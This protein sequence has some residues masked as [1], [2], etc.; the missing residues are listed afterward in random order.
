M[1][2]RAR[3]WQENDATFFKIVILSV[4]FAREGSL[5]SRQAVPN[6]EVLRFAQNDNHFVL[7]WFQ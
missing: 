1:R 3:E 6:A 7:D 2:P 5:H 4:F